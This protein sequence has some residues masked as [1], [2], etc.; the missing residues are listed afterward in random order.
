[1]S[2][3]FT[4]KQTGTS[5]WSTT[6]TAA[7][8]RKNRHSPQPPE[9]EADRDPILPGKINWPRRVRGSQEPDIES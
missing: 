3:R 2:Y 5:R 9:I 4:R 7:T 8:C 6:L 1:M